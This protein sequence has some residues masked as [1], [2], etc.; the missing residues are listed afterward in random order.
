MSE[1]TTRAIDL[2]EKAMAAIDRAV[3]QKPE[4][5][6]HDFSAAV[7]CL[8]ELREVLIGEFQAAPGTSRRRERLNC[9][10]AVI[11]MIVG[12]QYPIGGTPW[13]HV[14]DART[15]FAQLLAGLKQS[16]R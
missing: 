10:N 1:T 5:N 11:S 2:A 9:L 13:R 7:C 12:G 16:E 4:R 3:A 6:G 14:E 15:S 8:T